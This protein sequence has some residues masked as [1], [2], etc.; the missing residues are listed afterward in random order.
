[1]L[2]TAPHHPFITIFATTIAIARH[3]NI[4][5]RRKRLAPER[6]PEENTRAQKKPQHARKIGLQGG[7]KRGGSSMHLNLNL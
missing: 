1:M 4:R 3:C 7:G 6:S 5:R 2:S